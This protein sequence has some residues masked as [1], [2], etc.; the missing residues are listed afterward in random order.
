[1]TSNTLFG[2]ATLRPF[3]FSSFAIKVNVV[4]GLAFVQIQSQMM[5][6]FSKFPEGRRPTKLC[7]KMPH[8]VNPGLLTSKICD[9][10]LI[11]FL[12]PFN[13]RLASEYESWSNS[14]Q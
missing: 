1:M 13:Y 6:L 4:N 5:Q 14:V 12:H 11:R 7:L 8:L 2:T 3:N 10:Y 9:S